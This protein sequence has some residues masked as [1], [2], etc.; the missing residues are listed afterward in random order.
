MPP[1]T[2]PAIAP[3]LLEGLGVGVFLAEP[4]EDAEA[5]WDDMA[6]A[7]ATRSCKMEE[8]VGFAKPT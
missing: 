8:S 4:D 7:V 1:T 2:P 6:V 5:G 3:A